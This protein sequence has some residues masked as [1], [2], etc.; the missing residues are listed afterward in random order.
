MCDAQCFLSFCTDYAQCPECITLVES[1]TFPSHFTF[2]GSYVTITTLKWQRS[3]NNP[4]AHSVLAACP[5]N[6]PHRALSSTSSA[7]PRM[8][9]IKQDFYA[10][11]IH[12][13]LPGQPTVHQDRLTLWLSVFAVAAHTAAL[14]CALRCHRD[15]E[16]HPSAATH[17]KCRI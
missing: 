17:T 14:H 13:I 11:F 1:I 3:S 16:V 15:G 2:T 5:Q 4:S 9:R 12:F 8:S 6:N 7:C 10:I